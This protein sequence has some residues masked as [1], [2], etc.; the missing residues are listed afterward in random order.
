MWVFRGVL[1]FYFQIPESAVS[2]NA[3][4][5][6][7]HQEN[8]E[9]LQKIAGLFLKNRRIN[10]CWNISSIFVWY[11]FTIGNKMVIYSPPVFLCSLQDGGFMTLGSSSSRWP[12]KLQGPPEVSRRARHGGGS[13]R[14]SLRMRCGSGRIFSRFFCLGGIF[15]FTLPPRIMEV[16]N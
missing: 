16:E 10:K 13:G 7:C 3:C 4:V 11:F 5:R 6:K 12:P 1:D 15:R 8:V 9:H 2:L 14:G